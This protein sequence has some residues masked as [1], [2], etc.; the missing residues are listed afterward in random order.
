MK[1]VLF[2]YGKMGQLVEQT[3][4]LQG[5]QIS[6]IYSHTSGPPLNNL[7]SLSEADVAIDF[8]TASCVYDHLSLCLEHGKP[9]VIGT[10]GWDDQL[11]KVQNLVSEANGSCLYAPNFSIGVYL[12]QQLLRYAASLFQP[13]DTYDVTGI[14]MHHKQKVDSPSGTAKAISRDVLHHM[15]RLQ[16]FDFTCIRT[17]YVPGTHTVQFDSPEDTLTIAHQARNRNGFAQGALTAAS[18]LLNRK[19]FFSLDDMMIDLL[20]RGFACK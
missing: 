11:E 16:S 1:I 5:H 4:S 14:E 7:H 17:G 2:G 10:T 20:P 13:F 19:G 18:W 8:S 6:G 12:Y 3:A 9:I 15:P